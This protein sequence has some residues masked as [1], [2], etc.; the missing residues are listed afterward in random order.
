MSEF[1]RNIAI[2]NKMKEELVS[3]ST[4][5]LAQEKGFDLEEG[6]TCGGY[7]DC[8]CNHI[9]DS[10][11]IYIPSQNLLQKW[12]REV[13][14]IRVFVTNKF[15]GEFGY[16]IYIVNEENPV[17]KPFIRLTTFSNSYS[18]Y[19]KALESGIYEALKQIGL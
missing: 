2:L 5:K 1:F 3:L 17:G 7:P 15:S 9:R 13:H 14:T 8:I 11:Y 16:D 10:D 4:I 6:C 12:L 18:T 19:E